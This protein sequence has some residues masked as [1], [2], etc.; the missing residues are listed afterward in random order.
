MGN[1]NRKFK[2]VSFK[3]SE[4]D[5]KYVDNRIYMIQTESYLG[6]KFSDSNYLDLMTP[7]GQNQTSQKVTKRQVEMS[8]LL[9]EL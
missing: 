6:S 8:G 1:K 4:I 7:P 5:I 3:V 2:K 9:G